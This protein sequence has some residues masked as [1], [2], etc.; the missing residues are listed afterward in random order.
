MPIFA[1]MNSKLIMTDKGWMAR[2]FDLARRGLGRVSPNPPVGA[3]LVY[4]HRILGEGYHSYFGGPHAEVEAVRS[5]TPE[6]KHLIP[7]A[8]LYV[9]L[10]PCRITGKTPPCTDLI[11][12]EGITDVRVSTNDPNPLMAGSSLGLLR[13]KGIKITEGIL[14]DEG[15]ELIRTFTTNILLKRPHVKLK[16]AQSKNN[17]TGIIGEQVWLSQPET[18]VWV[19][20]QRSE[21]DAILIGARTIETDNPSLTT[22][23]YT[24]KSAHRVIYD[25]NG[26]LYQQY[27]VFNED[28]CKVFYFSTVENAVLEGTHIHKFILTSSE[29]HVT[30]ILAIL[31]ANQIGILLV[32]GGTYVQNMFIKQNMWD[33]AWVIKTQH[34]L[35][36]GIMAPNVRGR[37]MGEIRIGDDTIVGITRDSIK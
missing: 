37:K 22:R 18:G 5:V 36:E 23:H 29:D 12:W 7:S 3:V 1:W 10:E 21:A 28:G 20:K 13:S 8:T 27:H 33:E 25:P 35:G 16:W 11:L 34:E 15:K 2:C 4:E 19:H 6:E 17:Y 31:F 24:G 9:S 30:Q 14:A 26:R 32:E